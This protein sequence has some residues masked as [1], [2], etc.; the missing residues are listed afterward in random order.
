MC[1][2]DAWPVESSIVRERK[3]QERK[4]KRHIPMVPSRTYRTS[5]D[6]SP[7]RIGGQGLPTEFFDHCEQEGWDFYDELLHLKVS[8]V[9]PLIDPAYCA[10]RC[11]KEA[12]LNWDDVVMDL[13]DEMGDPRWWTKREWNRARAVYKRRHQKCQVC[14]NKRRKFVREIARLWS[15]I[16][17]PKEKDTKIEVDGLVYSSKRRYAMMQKAR[18]MITPVDLIIVMDEVIEELRK[19]KLREGK[20]KPLTLIEQL[21][22]VKDELIGEHHQLESFLLSIV[23]NRKA[24]KPVKVT[25]KHVIYEVG[26][27]VIKVEK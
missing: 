8:S 21:Q 20:R 17:I 27:V 2:R 9:N 5:K 7:R 24:R 3:R 11:R 16:F 1:P 14:R 22:Y 23:E 6:V 19:G 10:Y 18:S 12:R 26:N 4:A 13:I 25:S 15:I